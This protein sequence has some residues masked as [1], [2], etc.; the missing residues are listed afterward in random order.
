[1]D[2]ADIC[3]GC[4]RSLDEIVGWRGFDVETQKAVLQ[5]SQERQSQRKQP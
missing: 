1:L 5:R 2:N 4:G 3:L